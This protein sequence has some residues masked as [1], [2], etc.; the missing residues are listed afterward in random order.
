MTRVIPVLYAYHLSRSYALPTRKIYKSFI[1]SPT[2]ST[3]TFYA[4]ITRRRSLCR[5]C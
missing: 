1:L 4:W 2:R 5:A 3:I